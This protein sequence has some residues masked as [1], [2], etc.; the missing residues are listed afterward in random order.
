MRRLEFRRPILGR[1][2]WGWMSF[3][4]VL[5]VA[6]GWLISE[7]SRKPKIGRVAL[8]LDEELNRIKP[9]A[10]RLRLSAPDGGVSDDNFDDFNDL[11]NPDLIQSKRGKSSSGVSGLRYAQTSLSDSNFDTEEKPSIIA[12]V[13]NPDDNEP[14]AAEDLAPRKRQDTE[15]RK[16]QIPKFNEQDADDISPPG[17]LVITI[18][19][20]NIDDP[21]TAI[22]KRPL[23]NLGNKNIKPINVI[24]PTLQKPSQYGKLPRISEDGILSAKYYT[25]NYRIKSD[26]PSVAFM[27]TGLGLNANLTRRAIEELPGE[28][29]LAF[30]PY[31]KNLDQWI[32]QA[33][34]AGH[35]VLL[36]IPMESH[37][38]AS[39]RQIGPAG[40]LTSQTAEQNNKRLDWILSRG[41]GYFGVTNYLG[42]KFSSRE[43]AIMPVIQHLSSMGVAYIDDTGATTRNQREGIV[44]RDVARIISPAHSSS[45]RQAMIDDLGDLRGYAEEKGFALG[46]L[47]ASDESLTVLTAFFRELAHAEFDLAPASAVL[48]VGTRS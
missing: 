5:V 19:G 29:S 36:E 10:K 48:Y 39:I 31:A 41:E 42:S 23:V 47:A 7:Q 13:V 15:P 14:V 6:G 37:N 33:R 28:I 21:R 2:V 32:E 1:L 25:Q 26:K 44:A 20:R 38:P 16:I 3:A 43:E 35:E 34:A 12:R 17:E 4:V 45:D 40:L 30:A 24:L 11:Q 18:D 8:N 27:I 9:P 22:K 46:K